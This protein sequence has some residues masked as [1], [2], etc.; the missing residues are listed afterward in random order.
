MADIFTT[1]KRSQL[2]A[3]IRS[4]G[5]LSTEQ[6]ML[7]ILRA[8]K[9]RGWRR[10]IRLTLRGPNPPVQHGHLRPDFV[11][12]R[13]RLALFLDGCF[14]HGC[15]RHGHIPLTRSAFWSAK[16]ERNME[17][18]RAVSRALRKAGWTVVRI[19][20]HDLK[21]EANTVHKMFKAFART[22]RN[23]S[24]RS[25]QHRRVSCSSDP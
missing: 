8:N 19:W 10:H 1:S 16:L 18:D 5:N 9:M 7:S 4:Q 15:R 2:M 20:E 6:R 23:R 21:D 11:W 17:R 22:A 24:V 25:N 13:E 14:W 3:S 12:K